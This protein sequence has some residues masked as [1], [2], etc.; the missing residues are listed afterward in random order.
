MMV[1]MLNLVLKLRLIILTQRM[2]MFDISHVL[3]AKANKILLYKKLD[4]MRLV[5]EVCCDIR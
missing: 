3:A 5:G 1:F 2:E 4:A